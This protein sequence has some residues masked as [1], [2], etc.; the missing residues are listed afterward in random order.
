MMEARRSPQPRF[1]RRPNDDRGPRP[2]PGKPFFRDGRNQ[3]PPSKKF[4]RQPEIKITDDMQVT[5]GKH[6]GIQLKS[7][8]SPKV[9]PTARRVREA[10]FKTLNRRIRFARFLDLCAGSG[11]V[12]V[13]AISRGALLSTFVERSAK[14]CHFIKQNLESCKICSHGHGEICQYEVMPFLKKMSARKRYWDIVYFD[15]PYEANYDE[16]LECFGKGACVRPDGG[17][18]VVEHPAEMFFPPQIG[19][20]TRRRVVQEGDSALTFYERRK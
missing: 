19:C 18:L 10:L 20:L 16:V 12:G 13:E 1:F 11:A 9:R 5:D 2:G 6:K 8:Q 17:I 7:T 14:M 3:A 4:I 15:P